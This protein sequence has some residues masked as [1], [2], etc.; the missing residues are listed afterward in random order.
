MRMLLTVTV[1]SHV[2]TN[3]LSVRIKQSENFLFIRDGEMAQ[4]KALAAKSD[5]FT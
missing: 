2:L 3:P 4:V 1:L 5:N